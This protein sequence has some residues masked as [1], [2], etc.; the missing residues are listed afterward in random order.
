MLFSFFLREINNLC[1]EEGIKMI[2]FTSLVVTLVAALVV[3]FVFLLVGGIGGLLVFG[4]L[5]VCLLIIGV[6]INLIIKR[7]RT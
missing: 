1:Y 6:I 5:A 4:D 7:R 3:L 2:L